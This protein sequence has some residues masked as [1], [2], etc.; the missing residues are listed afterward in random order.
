M[1]NEFWHAHILHGIAIVLCDVPKRDASELTIS[2]VYIAP[3]L[4]GGPAFWREVEVNLLTFAN[5]PDMDEARK[6]KVVEAL[7][8]LSKKYQPFIEALTEK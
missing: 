1:P 3:V 7:R 6:K 2:L 5:Q 8:K 4:R